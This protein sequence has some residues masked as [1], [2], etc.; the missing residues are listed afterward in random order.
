MST[1]TTP[2]TMPPQAPPVRRPELVRPHHAVEITHGTPEQLVR[3]RM[4]L[5]H[6]ANFNDPPAYTPPSYQRM[7]LI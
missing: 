2:A 4:A 3:V 1:P 6:G 7:R 5:T